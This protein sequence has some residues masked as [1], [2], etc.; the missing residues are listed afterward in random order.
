MVEVAGLAYDAG[1][2][3]PAKIA[4]AAAVATAESGR[5]PTRLGDTGRAGERTPDGRHWGPSVGLW[6][7]RSIE[8]ESGKGTTRDRQKLTDPAHNAR[9]MVEISKSG[10][11]FSPWSVTK[12]TDPAGFLR[13]QAALPLAVQA[14]SVALGAK[15]VSQ[16]KQEIDEALDPVEKLAATVSDIAQTPVRV[17]N[18]F[19][20]PGTWR[21]IWFFGAGGL[22]LILGLLQAVKG[23]VKSV[24]TQAAQVVIPVGKAGKALGKVAK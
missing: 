6:Q 20:E 10:A 21:R 2:R 18:W 8:E 5:E 15:G 3:N 11:D 22:L 1:L 16:V 9:A 24:A 17:A 7:I 13:Y 23:P 19:T 12:P 14:T 4:Q